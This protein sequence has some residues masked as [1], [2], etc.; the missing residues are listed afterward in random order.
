[1]VTLSSTEAE[2]VG[3]SD[4]AREGIYFRRLLNVF[5]NPHSRNTVA[6]TPETFGNIPTTNPPQL[7]YMDNQSTMKIAMSSTS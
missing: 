5:I 7:L 4:A 3:S 2:Y 6:E 1:M